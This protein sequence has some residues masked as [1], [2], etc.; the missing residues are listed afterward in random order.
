MRK[1]FLN[2]SAYLFECNWLSFYFLLLFSLFGINAES[3]VFAEA[4]GLYLTDTFKNSSDASYSK[5]FYM[6]DV[7]ANLENKKKWYAGLHVDQINFSEN[8]TT[9]TSYTLT[10]TNLGIMFLYLLDKDGTFSVSAGYSL[11]ANGTYQATGAS[12]LKLSGSNYWVTLGVMPQ[13]AENLYMGLRWAYY[14]VSYNKSTVGS[15][16]TDVSYSRTLMMPLLGISW[17]Y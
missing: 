9:S 5:S 10:S 1:I 12:E 14:V 6:L 4:N 15:T 11:V 7:F 17:R 8:P 2:R 13:V 16:A 3:A